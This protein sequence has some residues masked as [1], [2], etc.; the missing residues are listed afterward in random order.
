MGL[1]FLESDFLDFLVI[2]GFCVAT[3]LLESFL[4][5]NLAVTVFLVGFGLGSFVVFF[6]ATL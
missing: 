6:A 5:T 3:G 2:R 4:V 1:G